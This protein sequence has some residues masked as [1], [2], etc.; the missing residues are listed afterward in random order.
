MREPPTPTPPRSPLPDCSASAGTHKLASLPRWISSQKVETVRT[1][2]AE[3]PAMLLRETLGLSAD[4]SVKA[5][6]LT[7]VD[8]FFKAIPYP[9]TYNPRRVQENQARAP[10]ARLPA[11]PDQIG[12]RSTSFSWLSILPA[13]VPLLF[14]SALSLSRKRI[15]TR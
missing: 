11:A 7:D 2:L 6:R 13:V 14:R 8:G 9:L 5:Y 4:G 3:D 12:P 10:A 1:L 15:S